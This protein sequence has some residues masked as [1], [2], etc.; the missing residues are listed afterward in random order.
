MLRYW[1]ANM[2]N[3]WRSGIAPTLTMFT[4][5]STLLCCALPALLISIGAGAVMVGITTAI[6]GIMWLSAHK[7]PLFLFAAVMLI[8]CSALVWRQRR[9]P[10]PLDPLQ[11]QACMRL[12][13]Y[14]VWM[15]ALSIATLGT[16]VFFAYLWPL[17]YL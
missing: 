8:A 13:R 4:S 5:L 1:V 6:P 9:S 10:C 16:G 2:L 12:R 7:G 17:I 14:S 15:L 11:A 3:Y